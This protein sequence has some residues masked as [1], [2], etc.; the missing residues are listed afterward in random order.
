MAGVTVRAGNCVGIGIAVL[1]TVGVSVGSTCGVTLKVGVASGDAVF[2]NSDWET[3][4]RSFARL[5]KN[6]VMVSRMIMNN[7][8]LLMM[9]NFTFS[10]GAV[11]QK[12]VFYII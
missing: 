4:D 3:L 11:A 9:F 5:A 7:K 10:P 6:A 1:V 2:E 8:N 12:K